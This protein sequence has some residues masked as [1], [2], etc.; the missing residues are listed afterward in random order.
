MPNLGELLGELVRAI[1]DV[2]NASSLRIGV[3]PT[4][5]VLGVLFVLL[6]LA[7]RPPG[8]WLTRDPAGLAGVAGA[9][10]LAAEAGSRAVV[11]LGSAGLA[12]AA[13]ATSRLQTLAALPILLH[14]A[15]AAARAG[16]PIEVTVNDPLAA[17]VAEATLDE[18]HQRTETP[19]RSGRSRVAFVGEGRPA[20]A[21]MALARRQAAAAAYLAGGLGEEG[22]LLGRGLGGETALRTAATAD[23][24]QAASAVLVADAALIGPELFVAPADLRAGPGERT[25]ARAANRLLILAMVVLTIGTVLSLGGLLDV[26]ALLLEAA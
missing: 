21:G 5:A 2:L 12:R 10:A 4:L 26:R 13:S 8:G 6:Q 16:V 14:V 23:A 17:I 22:L 3:I 19:E 18:A 1:G 20:A 15:R 24:A 7:A 25:I 11:S 9:M